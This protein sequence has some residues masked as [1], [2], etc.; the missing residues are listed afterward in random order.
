MRDPRELETI[1]H[2]AH[3]QKPCAPGMTVCASIT[4]NADPNKLHVRRVKTIL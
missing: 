1:Q 2:A 4:T 3:S